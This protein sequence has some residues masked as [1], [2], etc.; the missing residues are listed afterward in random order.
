[1]RVFT[2]GGDPVFERQT[3][4]TSMELS[5]AEWQ[6]AGPPGRFYGQV[7]ALDD[8][9]QIIVQSGFEPL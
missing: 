9:R 5:A 6:E 8:L 4:R 3:S 2:E 7:I 1:V